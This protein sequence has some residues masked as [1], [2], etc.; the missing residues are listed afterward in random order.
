MSGYQEDFSKSNNA[1]EAENRGYYP[2]SILAQ[3]LGVK[4]KAVLSLLHSAE[5]HHSSK[6]F[7]PV[8]YYSEEDAIEKLDA[9]KAFQEP[10]KAEAVFQN[11]RGSFLIWGGTRNHPKATEA[12]FSGATVTQKGDWF[13]IS[14]PGEAPF[15]KKKDTRGFEVFDAAGKRLNW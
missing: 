3:R 14:I 15:R 7:N 4:T 9:L 1:V 2:A 10:K 12:K 11:C 5:W 8:A 13:T 6:F